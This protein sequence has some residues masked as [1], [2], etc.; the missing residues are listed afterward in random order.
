MADETIELLSWLVEDGVAADAENDPVQTIRAWAAERFGPLQ[1]NAERLRWQLSNEQQ[2]AAGPFVLKATLH[3]YVPYLRCKWDFTAS[4]AEL[5][6]R[7]ALCY[8]HPSD[9]PRELRAV[10]YRYETPEP[11]QRHSMHHVQPI[12][13]FEGAGGTELPGLFRY[14]LDDAPTFP[15][16]ATD[17]AGVVGCMIVSLYG[18]DT[19]SAYAVGELAGS[20]PGSIA[21]IC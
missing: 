1:A 19:A 16:A 13:S 14:T 17:P 11:A 4:P 3:G 7:V 8:Q 9:A 18:L 21:A 15:L 12:R 10:G 2:G 6:L 20:L 5:R